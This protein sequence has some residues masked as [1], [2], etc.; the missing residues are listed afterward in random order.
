M[1]N[2]KEVW[3]EGEMPFNIYEDDESAKWLGMM[4]SP[5]IGIR[6]HYSSSHM[7]PIEGSR[8]MLS[9]HYFTIDGAEAIR[10]E[11]LFKMCQDFVK[12]GSVITKLMTKD[13]D[14]NGSWES[15][16]DKVHEQAAQA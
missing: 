6:I 9:M 14:D 1:S 16:L 8:G 15:Y 3:I 12:A 2:T 13:L 7:V 11:L 10:Y 4:N 5:A